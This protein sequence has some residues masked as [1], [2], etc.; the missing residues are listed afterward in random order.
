VGLDDLPEHRREALLWRYTLELD[1]DGVDDLVREAAGS[2]CNLL[3]D[4]PA[5]SE[6]CTAIL[7]D[8]GRYHM[9]VDGSPRCA[10]QRRHDDLVATILHHQW[11]HWWTDGSRYRAQPPPDSWSREGL[12]Y[13]CTDTVTVEWQ[14]TLTE[15]VT[16]PVLV[17]T[18]QRCVHPTTRIDW[19]G[20]QGPDTPEGRQR[21]QLVAALGRVCHACGLRPGASI[22]HDHFTGLV[23]GLLCR[24]CNTHIDGCL[25]ASGCVW[26]DYLNNPPAA[27]LR[28]RYPKPERVGRSDRAAEKIEYLGFDPLYRGPAAERR[29]YPARQLPPPAHAVGIDL[30]AVEEAPLF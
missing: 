20:Y 10:E 7:G 30:S 24:Y 9:L 28:L 29:R 14:V 27:H 8:D 18:R 16:D 15:A 2:Q 4:A 12:T 22:D 25:H 5:A 21:A 13:G 1:Y 23:R 11:C 26:A 19:P 17:P 3:W 6:D